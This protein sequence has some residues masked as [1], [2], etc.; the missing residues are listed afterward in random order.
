MKEITFR[1]KDVLAAIGWNA[2]VGWRAKEVLSHYRQLLAHFGGER[3]ILR[4]SLKLA[5][6][7]RN[8]MLA[9]AVGKGFADAIQVEFELTTNT[10]VAKFP[11]WYTDYSVPYREHVFKPMEFKAVD[12]QEAGVGIAEY[13]EYRLTPTKFGDMKKRRIAAAYWPETDTVYI[14]EVWQA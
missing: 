7:R 13:T 9:K 1:L 3:S 6:L 4:N 11:S 2:L 12:V 5:K 8:R 14:S 10:K